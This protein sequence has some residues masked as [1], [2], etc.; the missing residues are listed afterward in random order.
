M[1]RLALLLLAVF[2]LKKMF[3]FWHI[4]AQNVAMG[5][6]ILIITVNVSITVG[7]CVCI[8]AC[9]FVNIHKVKVVP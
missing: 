2:K 7:G 6:L 9:A 3:F 4:P 5:L 8:G 1:S